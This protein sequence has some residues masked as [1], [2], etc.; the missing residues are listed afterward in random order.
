MTATA[1]PSR[2]P[3]PGPVGNT[4][5]L[6]A[7]L[8]LAVLAMRWQVEPLQWRDPG[9]GRWWFAGVVL[10]LWAGFTGAV[11]LSRRLRRR[12]ADADGSVSAGAP[13]DWLV[14]HASQTGYAEQLAMLTA[15]ALRS[16]GQRVRL[17]PLGKL[18]TAAL[19]AAGQ[20]LFIVSTT[21]EG[22]PPDAAMPFVRR[23][24]TDRAGLGTLR[25][26]LLALG[27]REYDAYC[28]F[29][30]RLDGWLRH[31]HA[32]ALFDM[33]EVDNGDAGALRLWQQHLGQLAG[34]TDLPDWSRPAYQPWRLQARRH[35]NPGSLG[36]AVF[37]IR[38]EPEDPTRLH[39]SAGDI[40]EIGPR[41]AEADVD[42]WLATAGVDGS[43]RVELDGVMQPLRD[44]LAGAK[45]PAP[46]G[47]EGLDAR[48]I[49]AALEPLPHREYSIAS[50]PGEGH[51][52]LLVRQMRHPDGRLG[53]GSGWLTEHAR[54]GAPVALRIRGNRAFHLHDDERPLI[55]IG[56]GTGVAGLRALLR[57]RIERGHARNWLLFGE[58]QRRHDLHFGDELLGW[59][60]LG[61]LAR[62]DLAFSRDDVVRS[63]EGGGQTVAQ[64]R[65]GVYVQDL[66]REQRTRLQE[67]I[68]ADAAIHV[69]GSLQGMAP[70][71]DAALR[72]CLG[73][74]AVD[75]LIDEGRYRRD[76]Y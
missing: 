37:D 6:L 25:Y 13:V 74:D 44:L 31:S 45:L 36:G 11:A 68:A 33:I 22:D 58:R 7:L 17:V 23:T 39:W 46:T 51:L 5:A 16:A 61:W 56:N 2:R 12:A 26:G 72:D 75:D 4:L 29:G 24:L 67:W 43:A 9:P 55:L 34:K 40:A 73:D 10:G 70:G 60:T 30:H 65:S 27:D 62:L 50:I 15:A 32:H 52:R 19:A 69:C 42:A 35:L 76:V 71:V 59:Q 21:G 38:L 64:R 47:V 28:A 57:A 48:Q 49:A 14:A 3:D 8:T 1:V 41:H 54:I 53:S 66:L 63:D 20:A 18:D